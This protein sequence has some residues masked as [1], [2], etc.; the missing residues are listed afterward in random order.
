M[1]DNARLI[2]KLADR[3]LSNIGLTRAQWQALGNLKRLGPLTQA[4]LADV[5]E[6]QT[7]TITRLIDRLESSGW[8]VRC[9][10]AHDRRVKLVS[11]TEK[12]KSVMDEV[13]AIGGKMREDMLVD[14]PQH[15]REHLVETLTLVKS[16]LISL[17]E[18]Q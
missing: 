4:T 17:L 8:V 6:L 18:T 1:A 12:A 10:S 11:M 15:E 3:R 2:R 14:L 16:R 7:A 5:M 13:S 9:P